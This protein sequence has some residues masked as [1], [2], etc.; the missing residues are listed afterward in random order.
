MCSTVAMHTHLAFSLEKLRLF[1]HIREHA[2]HPGYLLTL[3][4]LCNIRVVLYS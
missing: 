4:V 3:C 1:F 2:E